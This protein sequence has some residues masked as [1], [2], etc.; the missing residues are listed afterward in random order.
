MLRPGDGRGRSRVDRLAGEALERFAPNRFPI[1]CASSQRRGLAAL[2]AASGTGLSAGREVSSAR[3]VLR[4]RRKARHHSAAD[5]PHGALTSL[6]HISGAG[7][8]KYSPQLEARETILGCPSARPIANEKA[9]RPT[10]LAKDQAA[11]RPG[12]THPTKEGRQP[13]D[14]E[15]A[16]SSSRDASRHSR[17][18]ARGL[19][20]RRPA[21]ETCAAALR[22][23]CRA[24]PPP[25]GHVAFGRGRYSPGRPVLK[26]PPVQFQ[27]GTR[28]AHGGRRH[29][30]HPGHG[31]GLV[32]LE[33][34][35]GHLPFPLGQAGQPP[36][37]VDPERRLVRRAD[38]VVFCQRLRQVSSGAPAVVSS[39]RSM[40][41][42][43]S[44]SR[45]RRGGRGRRGSPGRERVPDKALFI[46]FRKLR[47]P[48]MTEGFD[49]L[50][51]V[52]LAPEGRFIVDE[53]TG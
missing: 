40:L 29:I 36:P 26:L 34:Q 1:L 39:S 42:I 9:V 33:Q 18:P 51:R 16:S 17:I 25:A 12:G 13:G 45:R 11:P 47:E 3:S 15:P 53:F 31:A 37:E 2:P 30:E 32:P 27:P 14:G 19:T 21:P 50:Y 10:L 7:S 38:P 43:L 35:L 28:L 20:I 6:R 24:L 46:T 48:T 49:R 41:T 8:G 4:K 52:R 22:G 5:S 23:P 44:P